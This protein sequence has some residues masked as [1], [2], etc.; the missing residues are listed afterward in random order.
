MCVCV[1]SVCRCVCVGVCVCVCVFV[2]VCMH[3]MCVCTCVLEREGMVWLAHIM[4]C[5]SELRHVGE[6]MVLLVHKCC[7]CPLSKVS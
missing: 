5:V 2:C 1:P 7:V 4:L 6:G 3:I